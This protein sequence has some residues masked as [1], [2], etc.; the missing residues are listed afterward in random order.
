M[1]TEENLYAIVGTIGE[2]GTNILDFLDQSIGLVQI[3]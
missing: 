2:G 3:S 1:F